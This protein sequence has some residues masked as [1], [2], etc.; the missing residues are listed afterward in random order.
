M[1]KTLLA[2]F[3]TLCAAIH[4]A[5]PF[6]HSAY[7]RAGLG[8]RLVSATGDGPAS[9]MVNAEIS[10]GYQSPTPLG[11]ELALSLSNFDNS[12]TVGLASADTLSIIP[13]LR[14]PMN[15]LF[16]RNC[17]HT[18]GLQI[19]E[20]YISQSVG[21]YGGYYSS[22]D[23]YQAQ[24]VTYGLSYRVEQMLGK[25][26]SLGL[27]LGYQ[28]AVYHPTDYAGRP[29]TNLDGSPRSLDYSGPSIKLSLAFWMK[30]PF[31]SAADQAADVVRHFRVKKRTRRRPLN[32]DP[33][34]EVIK[35]PLQSGDEA[36]QAKDYLSASTFYKQAAAD[37]A[38]DRWAWQGLGNALYFLGQKRDALEAYERAFSFS[39][40]DEKLQRL[41][42][43]LGK[44]LKP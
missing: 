20:S 6:E 15:G 10:L 16:G 4:A 25:R 7:V 43:R 40:G 37:N 28:W 23:Y 21:N 19:G 30:R 17:F 8:E 2:I 32:D 11:V 31:I 39:Q 44:E 27:D 38:A 1:K 26:V 9:G 36:M 18:V 33:N 41:I 29:M 34:S 13:T 35:N 24:T 5:A 12:S 22:Y 14:I 3:L 42:E